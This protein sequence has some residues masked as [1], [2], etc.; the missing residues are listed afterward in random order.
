MIRAV[1]KND[2][3]TTK[4]LLEYKETNIFLSNDDNET[5]ISINKNIYRNHDEQKTK[6]IAFA[7][8]YFYVFL[9]F[10]LLLYFCFKLFTY[11]WIR[12]LE[13]RKDDILPVAFLLEDSKEIKTLI[14]E[15]H[16][17]RSIKPEHT[18]MMIKKEKFII[19]FLQQDKLQTLKAA[20]ILEMF[21][22]KNPETISD[23]LHIVRRNFYQ[24]K[25]EMDETKDRRVWS[26]GI[27]RD[28]KK[29]F[30]RRRCFTWSPWRCLTTSPSFSSL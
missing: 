13:N 7:F 26:R 5:A 6:N 2:E 29:L 22:D 15:G 18:A 25:F 14:D 23:F 30:Q 8:Y 19:E 4:V 12:N 27:R 1:T 10:Y 3:D 9:L 21:I 17:L 11:S 24:T 16:D 28:L 20:E